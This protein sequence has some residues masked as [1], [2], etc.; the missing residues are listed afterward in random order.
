MVDGMC[1]RQGWSP[2]LYY[3]SALCCV[4]SA[5]L[6][7]AKPLEMVESLKHF[8][9]DFFLFVLLRWGTLLVCARCLAAGPLSY[10]PSPKGGPQE[11]EQTGEGDLAEHL[12]FLFSFREKFIHVCWSKYI[13]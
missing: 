9:F 1:V 2:L 10:V 11:L 6:K 7:L 12:L 5:K 8:F 3:T 13:S 4:L